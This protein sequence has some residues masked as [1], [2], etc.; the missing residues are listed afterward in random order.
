MSYFTSESAARSPIASSTRLHARNSNLP[1]NWKQPIA[2]WTIPSSRCFGYWPLERTQRK[3]PVATSTGSVDPCLR[4]TSAGP[5]RLVT[6]D[7]HPDECQGGR[8]LRFLPPLEPLFFPLASREQPEAPPKTVT[9]CLKKCTRKFLDQKLKN[10]N[11]TT[12]R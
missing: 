6:A 2:R 12:A 1:P 4:A 3:P 11:I 5:I 9:N 7:R 8:N 10:L